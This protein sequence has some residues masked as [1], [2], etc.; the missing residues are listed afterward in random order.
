RRT[1]LDRHAAKAE[2]MLVEAG[3]VKVARQEPGDRIVVEVKRMTKTVEIPAHDTKTRVDLLSLVIAR[4]AKRKQSVGVD[5]GIGSA[6]H[7][8]G[9]ADVAVL[10]GEMS[11]A[12]APQRVP[13]AHRLG[14]E[15][16]FDKR[17]LHRSGHAADDLAAPATGAR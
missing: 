12:G 2:R 7:S 15:L 10:D 13:C 6:D 17:T 1:L 4:I 9:D 3:Q 14:V 5:L 11:T 16:A 8:V